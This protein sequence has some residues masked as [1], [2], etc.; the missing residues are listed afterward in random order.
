M[1]SAAKIRRLILRDGRSIRSV[2]R[3]TGLSRN[4]IKKYLND[5]TPPRYQRSQAPVRHKLQGFEERLR[6]L[7]EQDQKRA[8]RERRTAVKLY[9]QLVEEGYTG[10]YSPV[11]RFVKTLKAD[12]SELLHAY[13][14]LHFKAGDALQFDWS[15]E[16]VVLGGVEQKIKVAHFR[17]CHSRKSFIVAYPGEPQEMVLDAFVRALAFYGG[18]PRRV[19]ID[20]PKTMVTYVSRSKDRVYH[21]RFLALMNH[22]VMEPVACTPASGWEKGQIENQVQHIRQWL[23]TPKLDFSDLDALNAWL[24]LRCNELGYIPFPKSGGALLFHLISK[25]YEQTSVIIT[26]NLEFGEWVSVFG[27]AK[28]TTA[29]LDRVTHHCS[30]IETGNNSFR[31]AQSKNSRVQ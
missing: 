22:Y 12:G 9:E 11:C 4:T 6:S 1:E 24:S 29:L 23:F 30:I 26:T 19:I 18:V 16:H 25:L 8:R 17:L 7:F 27:D 15:E 13:I 21:P 31:F 3:S 2:S 5:A 10:S 14:P 28:M 20:N